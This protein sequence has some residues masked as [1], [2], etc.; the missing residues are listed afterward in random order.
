V[1]EGVDRGVVLKGVEKR[2]AVVIP[3]CH[4]GAICWSSRGL[5]WCSEGQND[6]GE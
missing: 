6:E 4:I 2:D 5:G 1:L 3:E